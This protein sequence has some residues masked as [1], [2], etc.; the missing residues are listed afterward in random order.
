MKIKVKY[1]E[2]PVEKIRVR[3]LQSEGGKKGGSAKVPKGFACNKEVASNAGKK[4]GSAKVSKGFGKMTPERRKEIA[5][6][7]LKSRWGK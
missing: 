4:G 3:R 7:A 6:R 2:T 1:I 5:A